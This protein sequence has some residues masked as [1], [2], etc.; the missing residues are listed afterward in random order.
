METLN[1]DP[2]PSVLPRSHAVAG[3]AAGYKPGEGLGREKQGIA[4]PIDARMRP[5][6]MGMGF[7]D[8]EEHKLLRPNEAAQIAANP[9]AA[10][11]VKEQARAHARRKA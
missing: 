5:K 4:K 8:Y 11:D 1:V 2:R 9:D 7:N 6:G 3:H 10:G